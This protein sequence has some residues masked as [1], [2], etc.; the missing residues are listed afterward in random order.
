MLSKGDFE[1]T[2]SQMSTARC[3]ELFCLEK[4]DINTIVSVIGWPSNKNETTR[5]KYKVFALLVYCVLLWRIATVGRWLDAEDMF[6]KHR[7]QL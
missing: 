3:L 4:K 1:R 7:F 6:S 2:F 5:N